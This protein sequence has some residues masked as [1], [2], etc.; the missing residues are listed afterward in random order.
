MN[1]AEVAIEAVVTELSRNLGSQLKAAYLFGSFVQGYYQP[2]E[3]DINFLFI[4][5]DE[6][7]FFEIRHCFL[8][9]C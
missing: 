2:G 3:S 5:D 4:V 7:D 1:N 8:P 9:V 6:A